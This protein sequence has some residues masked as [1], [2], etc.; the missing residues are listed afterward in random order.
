MSS[1]TV[2]GCDGHR[3]DLAA[4]HRTRRLCASQSLVPFASGLEERPEPGIGEAAAV[5]ASGASAAGGAPVRVS[6]RPISTA[7]SRVA[8][9][10]SRAAD[11]GQVRTTCWTSG[12][13]AHVSA[14]SSN[15]LRAAESSSEAC[16][17]PPSSGFSVSR[18][19]FRLNIAVTV[20]RAVEPG[21]DGNPAGL[22]LPIGPIGWAFGHT[23]PRLRMKT[24]TGH[25]SA[26]TNGD[27]SR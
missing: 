6:T 7:L 22:S 19:L 2:E 8:P 3:A 26:A 23:L 10:P 17:M 4:V 20:T 14:R 21:V 15:S 5:P 18:F 24:S 25:R 12:M 11:R 1:H 16:A 9:G 27:E 13:R